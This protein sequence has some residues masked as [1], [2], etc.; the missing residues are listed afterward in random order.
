M[1]F[2]SLDYLIHQN[3]LTN[4]VYLTLLV[5]ALVAVSVGLTASF[6]HR[7]NMRYRDLTII[8]FLT[9]LFFGGLTF[10]NLQNTQAQN[11]QQNE[12]ATF[13]KAYASDQK[14]KKSTLAF[15]STTMQDGMI[16]KEGKS[17]YQITLSKDQKSYSRTQVYLINNQV[18]VVK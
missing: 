9:F 6:R 8:A 12:M 14:V 2:Y 3:N 18:E 17:F 4:K 1:T 16:A 11:L 7:F 10:T 5:V 13:A 15:N